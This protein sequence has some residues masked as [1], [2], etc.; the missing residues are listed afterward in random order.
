VRVLVTGGSGFIGSHVVDRLLRHGHQPRIFDL[1]H[2]RRNGS[3]AVEC[4]T[5]DILDGSSL[6]LAM[7]SCDAVIHLAAVADVNQVAL[8]PLRADLVNTRGTAVVLEAARDQDIRHVVYGSTIWVYDQAP[9]EQ[10]LDEDVLLTSPEHLYT[11]TKLAGE[12]Y[13][14]AYGRMFGLAPTILRFG[15]P[16]GP[17]ARAATVVATFVARALAGEPINING[18]GSQARQFVYVEDLADGVVAALVEEARGRTYNL[19]GDETVSVREIAAIVQGLIGDVEVVHISERL[20]DL[21]RVH[22]SSERARAEL[23]WHATTSFADGVARYLAWLAGTNGSP[24][25][26]TASMIAGSAAAV[27]RQESGAL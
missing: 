12:M 7:R 8:D 26:P 25:A 19:V 15:I 13:C 20:G 4:V 10:A 2:S 17:R 6:R 21:G 1:V 18:D 11:A 5:G 24:S 9:G 14:R 27:L 3:G 23:G 22:I 16:H